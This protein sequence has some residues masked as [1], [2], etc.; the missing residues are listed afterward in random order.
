MSSTEEGSFHSGLRVGNYILGELIGNGAFGQV[1]KATHHERPKRIVA[2][3]VI[4]DPRFRRQLKRE[5]GIPEFEHP[6]IVRILDSDTR[7][8]DVPYIVF[9]FAAG[10][11]LANLI[12]QNSQGIAENRVRALLADILAGLEVAHSQ[13]VVHRDVKPSNILLNAN[14]EAM[15]ADFGLSLNQDP[16][17]ARLHS[18][19]QSDSISQEHQG[20]M[21]GTLAY[22]APEI[23]EGNP[24]SP[25]ADIFSLGTL[26]FEMLT[27]RR[28]AGLEF[29]EQVRTDLQRRHYWDSL[30]Y[31]ATRPSSDRY[32]NAS[33][34]ITATRSGPKPIPFSPIKTS[35]ISLPEPEPLPQ[36]HWD[37]LRLRWKEKLR[38]NEIHERLSSEL[39]QKKTI[40]A[41]HHVNVGALRAQCASVGEE[42]ESAR[43]RLRDACEK[44][45]DTLSEQLEPL[46][47]KRA[48]LLA[49][50]YLPAHP[51]VSAVDEK[52]RPLRALVES[53]ISLVDDEPENWLAQCMLEWENTKKRDIESQESFLKKFGD[54][55]DNPFARAAKER[56]CELSWEVARTE[57]TVRALKLFLRKFGYSRN[58]FSGR[59]ERQMNNLL[60]VS[61]SQASEL[62]DRFEERNREVP[63]RKRRV[64]VVCGG[65]FGLL[66]GGILSGWF[67]GER[68][69][70]SLQLFADFVAVIL[71]PIGGFLGFVVAARPDAILISQC[72]ILGFVAFVVLGSLLGSFDGRFD[73]LDLIAVILGIIVGFL[74]YHFD[75]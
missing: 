27:G 28:P 26:L 14:G 55:P 19:L 60:F 18:V 48:I 67:L 21:A 6:N 34:M 29:P 32:L 10:G 7:F 74:R 52:M 58:P 16:S 51:D 35:P 54:E 2:I 13:G 20:A 8:A 70:D 12:S 40:F 50:G 45:R 23:R 9:A 53:V 71:G 15:I 38:L 22:M 24:A 17:G 3:K 64:F 75:D 61:R 39:E 41:D 43:D 56:I 25:A 47:C 1:W 11:N 57:N 5:S 66:F 49:Q 42:R 59:A 62:V 31:W 69:Q 37:A 68:G 44:L 65:I 4:A 30:F 36:D 63:K 72:S 73:L 33:E 46:A